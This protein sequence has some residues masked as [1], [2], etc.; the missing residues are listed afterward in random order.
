MRT[1]R[2]SPNFPTSALVTA[3]SRSTLK[4]GVARVDEAVNAALV[5]KVSQLAPAND[6]ANW[7]NQIIF[8]DFL[9]ENIKDDIKCAKI[10]YNRHGFK[11]WNGWQNRCKSRPLPDVSKCK[12][13]SYWNLVSES[14][15]ARR[16]LLPLTSVLER[17]FLVFFCAAKHEANFSFAIC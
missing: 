8:V 16:L 5:A 10:I 14:T 7:F 3:F 11:Y 15:H 17:L 12:M 2:K 13:S 1:L 6:R 9:N 4:S